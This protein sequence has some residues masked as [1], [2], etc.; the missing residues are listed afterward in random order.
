[1]TFSVRHDACLPPDPVLVIA[2]EGWVDAG[3]AA[4]SAAQFLLDVLSSE[5]L[6]TFGGD[7]LIDQ[8]GRRPRMRVDD[9]VR[10]AIRFA[11][12]ELRVGTDARGAGIALL[13]G[14]EPDYRWQAFAAEVSRYALE[15]RARLVVGLGAFPVAA[16]HTRPIALAATASD[17]TL[18]R[19]VGFMPG[20]LDVPAGIADVIGARCT[21]AG[22]PSVG[23]WARVPHYVAGMSFP[24]AALALIEGLVSLS[25]CTLD[26]APLELEA[27]AGQRRV[28]ALIAESEEHGEMV[29][30]L[31]RQYDAHELDDLEIVIEPEIPS[32]E[33]IAAE[34]ERFLRGEA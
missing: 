33:E 32:G 3:F 34:L 27:E 16:P 15:L 8:R 18:A 26:V 9:G 12:P 25:G 4:A 22:V 5:T 13:V 1:M 24:A 14:P 28:D 10:Q 29:R 20:A 17:A 7:E 19:K 2:L 21:D 23:L 31:E 6:A 11:E 30:K